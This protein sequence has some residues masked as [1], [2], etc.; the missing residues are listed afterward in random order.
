MRLAVQESG[1]GS[2]TAVLIHGIMSDSRAWH[3]VTA[4]LEEHGF[5]VLAVD[6]AG[7][8]RSPR[9]RTLLARRPGP[10]TWWR[11]SSRCSTARPTS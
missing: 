7:H 2:K 5:R 6:L 1:N 8:G 11:P 4:E 3:R 10:T 9:A